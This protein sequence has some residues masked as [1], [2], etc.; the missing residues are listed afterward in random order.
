LI[1][2]ADEIDE[3]VERLGRALRRAAAE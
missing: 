2:T 3:A 1:I